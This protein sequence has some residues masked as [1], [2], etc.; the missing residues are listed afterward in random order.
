M[1]SDERAQVLKER[2][3]HG[4]LICDGAYGSTLSAAG[5]SGGQSL[6]L[7]NVEQPELVRAAHRAF[8]EAGAEMLETNTFQGNSLA[9]GRHGLAGRARELNLAGAHLAREVAGETVS[10]WPARS[11]PPA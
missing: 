7:Y 4:L 2:L 3:Q 10:S 9:L 6:E 8:L 1:T 5:H 11:G